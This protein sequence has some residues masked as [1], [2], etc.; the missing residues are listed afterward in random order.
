MRRQ[1]K[2]G[3]GAK[4]GAGGKG[5]IDCSKFAGGAGAPT[6]PKSSGPPESAASAPE[7]PAVS[8]S[9]VPEG[10]ATEAEESTL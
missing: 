9:T 6:A 2:G 4:G 3:A 10:G 1:S 7:T 5:G 8:E